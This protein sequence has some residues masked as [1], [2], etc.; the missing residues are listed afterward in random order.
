MATASNS[1]HG[2]YGKVV[3]RSH[4]GEPEDERSTSN[5]TFLQTDDDAGLGPGDTTLQTQSTYNT[6]P[7]RKPLPYLTLNG[8]D[9]PASAELTLDGD[10]GTSTAGQVEPGHARNS[11]GS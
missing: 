10:I 6:W 11:S 8:V 1:Q 7:K 2:R 4:Y 3:D 9:I 5:M